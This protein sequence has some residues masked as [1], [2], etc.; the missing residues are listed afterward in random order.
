MALR[1]Q[2]QQEK[3]DF[4]EDWAEL[5]GLETFRLFLSR[6]V[7]M[8]DQDLRLLLAASDPHSLA[9]LQGRVTALRQVREL[10]DLIRT[11]VTNTQLETSP[12]VG[13]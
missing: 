6:V 4:L 7:E 5:H 8:E 9:R 11:E 3:E 13:T 10:H 1:F 2:R 12:N